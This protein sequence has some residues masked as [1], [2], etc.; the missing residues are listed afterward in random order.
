M[1]SND[2]PEMFPDSA[3]PELPPQEGITYPLIM[4]GENVRIAVAQKVIDRLK[5][6]HNSLEAYVILKQHSAEI[7]LALEIIKDEAISKLEGKEDLIFG[8]K[9]QAKRNKAFEYS[10][11]QLERI[12]IEIKTLQEKAKAIK[13]LH[14]IQ[15][16]VDEVTGEVVPKANQ[17]KEGI[18]ISITLPK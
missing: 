17:T 6:E 10:H 14:E 16:M 2:N 7:D 15:D 12:A 18:N 11:P 3:M 13:R 9:V 4:G 5:Q 1:N 8:A